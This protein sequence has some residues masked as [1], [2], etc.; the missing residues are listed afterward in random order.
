M[1][2]KNLKQKLQPMKIFEILN[3]QK[4]QNLDIPFFFA[5]CF[6][7]ENSVSAEL[8]TRYLKSSSAAAIWQKK[9][10]RCRLFLLK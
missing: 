2:E 10:R 6:K 4:S 5:L 8:S 1:S 9:Q 7:K 3:N